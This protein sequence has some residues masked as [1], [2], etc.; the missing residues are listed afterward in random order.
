MDCSECLRTNQGGHNLRRSGEYKSPVWKVPAHCNHLWQRGAEIDR[1]NYGLIQKVRESGESFG[2][3]VL[4]VALSANER[5][6]LESEVKIMSQIKCPGILPVVDPVPC[7]ENG[8]IIQGGFVMPEMVPNLWKWY[9]TYS[10]AKLQC[11]DTIQRQLSDALKCLHDS[12]FIHGD[13]KG[14]Q[15]LYKSLD[16]KNCPVGLEISDFG[17]SNPRT[18]T[19]GRDNYDYKYSGEYYSISGHLVGE[20]FS[21][22][23]AVRQ[24]S[25]ANPLALSHATDIRKYRISSTIDW[26]SFL[27][28]MMTELALGDDDWFNSLSIPTNLAGLD[29]GW[30]S[31]RRNIRI[32]A[33]HAGDGF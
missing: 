28:E 9:D 29:C 21:D 23:Q 33:G 4:K 11:R 5:A 20:M 26:C 13:F 27:L 1:G 15:V 12:N 14:D 8:A 22:D 17:L 10:F 19:S 24:Y 2:K 25:P 16:S 6:E 3:Y 32:I 7:N 30:M 31:G 18:N